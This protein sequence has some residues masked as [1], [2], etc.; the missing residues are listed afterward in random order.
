M[1]TPYTYAITY[2]FEGKP[3]WLKV[4]TDHALTH[5]E[6]RDLLVNLQLEG[7]KN[8]EMMTMLGAQLIGY[9]PAVIPVHRNL[10]AA[11]K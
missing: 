10:D 7:I 11:L 1:T 3:G 9:T 2:L 8:G 6:S 4:A 5:D